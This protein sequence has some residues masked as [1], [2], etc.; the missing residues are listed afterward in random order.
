[1]FHVRTNTFIFLVEFY[2]WICNSIHIRCFTSSRMNI[3]ALLWFH[4]MDGT[5]KS[6]LVLTDFPFETSEI[7]DVNLVSFNWEVLFCYLTWHIS[8][9]VMC[10]R[11]SGMENEK[12]KSSYLVKM[13]GFTACI[14][15]TFG[16]FLCYQ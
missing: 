7:I 10:T 8:C 9:N 15:H 11:T 16:R 1:M 3:Q 5:M 14:L 4:E 2:N 6:S 12:I 13:N